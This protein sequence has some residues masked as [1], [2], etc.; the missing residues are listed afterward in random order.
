MKL[1]ERITVEKFADFVSVI[2]NSCPG[3]RILSIGTGYN[4][5]EWHYAIYVKYDGKEITFR[6]P[7]YDN[8]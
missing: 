3:G 2:R 8:E 6:V 4:G 7:C 1:P 5:D